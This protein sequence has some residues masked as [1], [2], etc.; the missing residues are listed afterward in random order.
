MYQNFWMDIISLLLFNYLLYDLIV[1]DFLVRFY[2]F[3]N[4]FNVYYKNF[5]I[6]YLFKV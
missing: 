2:F 6:I 1:I 3:K 5:L 4:I